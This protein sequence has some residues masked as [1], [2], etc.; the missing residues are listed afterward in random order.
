MFLNIANY[1]E[2]NLKVPPKILFRSNQYRSS[3]IR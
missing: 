1:L 3:D 2:L